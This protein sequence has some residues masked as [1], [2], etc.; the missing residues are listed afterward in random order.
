MCFGEVPLQFLCF[1]EVPLLF[2]YSERY[3]YNSCFVTAT[4]CSTY[5]TASGP[6][7]GVPGGSV[8]PYGRFCPRLKW[9]TSPTGTLSSSLPSLSH[10]VYSP[11]DRDSSPATVLS[12]AAASTPRRP[13]TPPLPSTP[14]PPSTPPTTP[15]PTLPWTPPPHPH[16]SSTTRPST[17][18]PPPRVYLRHG[19]H[20]FKLFAT[21]KGSPSYQLPRMPGAGC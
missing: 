11:C 17:P 8:V 9:I 12:S 13:L 10:L 18:T 7:A 21:G 19:H 16:P 3:H 14:P 15:S 20:G 5:G 4:P 1:G 6:P 2:A